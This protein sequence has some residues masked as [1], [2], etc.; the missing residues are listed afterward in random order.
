MTWRLQVRHR[1][2]YVYDGPVVAS[3]NEARMTPITDLHQT[4][5][6]ADLVT[7][8]R[9]VLHRYW[10]YWGTQVSAFDLHDPHD[11]LTITSTAVTTVCISAAFRVQNPGAA[12]AAIMVTG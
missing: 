11:R 6:S 3:Y 9:T 12:T 4:T 8:P 7:E 1:T 2:G 5:I 10:D